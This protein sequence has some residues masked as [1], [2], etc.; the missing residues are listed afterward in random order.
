MGHQLLIY[1]RVIPIG[2]GSH[3]DVS[4]QVT[5]DYGFARRINSVPLLGVEFAAGSID[6]PIVF[7][8]QGTDLFPAALLGLRPDHN[9]HVAPD[10]SWRGGYLPAFLR[11]YPFVFSREEGDPSDSFTLCIDESHPGFNREGR[12]DRLFDADGKRS[13]YL[14]KALAF[15]SEFQTQFHRTRLFCERLQQLGLLDDAQARYR[16]SL[17]REGSMGGFA[18]INRARLKALGKD[19]V[20]RMFQTDQL[21]LCHAHLHSLQNILRLGEAARFGAGTDM[22]G[23]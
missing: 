23:A 5:G 10:G 14:E 12:G 8:R 22:R 3:A 1:D 2:T 13:Q 7:A 9:D 16:D 17:G 4:V 19:D 20:R 21:D 18:V 11:R 15:T 6:H